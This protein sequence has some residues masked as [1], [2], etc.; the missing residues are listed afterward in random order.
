MLRSN[1]T[2]FSWER[3]RHPVL[4]S[5]YETILGICPN[6][7]ILQMSPEKNPF[8]DTFPGFEFISIWF[9]QYLS[10]EQQRSHILGRNRVHC[11]PFVSLTEKPGYGTSTALKQ[12]FK[13][14]KGEKVWSSG[15]PGHTRGLCSVSS[16]VHLHFF[17]LLKLHTKDHLMILIYCTQAWRQSR[18]TVLQILSS[19]VSKVYS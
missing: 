13:M 12:S 6:S 14:V 1:I 7:R 16:T 5:Y 15:T 10:Q 18:T 19:S 8:Y 9:G 4:F 17:S 3:S 2:S 11:F